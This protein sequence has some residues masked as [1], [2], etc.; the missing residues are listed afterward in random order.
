VPSIHPSNIR[1]LLQYK[2]VFQAS[3]AGMAYC[4]GVGVYEAAKALAAKHE[5]SPTDLVG[6][7]DKRS[8]ERL[9]AEIVK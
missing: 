4:Y 6:K 7:W 1:I 8:P 3:A 2:D 5:V 9:K